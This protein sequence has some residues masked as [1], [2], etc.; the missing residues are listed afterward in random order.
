MTKGKVIR[1]EA[2]AIVSLDQWIDQT[3][4]IGRHTSYHSELESLIVDAVHIGIQ[5][6]LNGKVEFDEDWNIVH[7]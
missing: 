1:A 2:Y 6:A 5:M 3:G 7:E 4:A